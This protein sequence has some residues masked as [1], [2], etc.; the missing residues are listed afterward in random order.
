MYYSEAL[1]QAF[2]ECLDGFGWPRAKAICSETSPT[3]KLSQVSKRM[4]QVHHTC[5][6]EHVE[7][8]SDSPLVIQVITVAGNIPMIYSMSSFYGMPCIN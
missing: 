3:L 1:I 8:R 6:T 2:S 7:M 5:V 4:S